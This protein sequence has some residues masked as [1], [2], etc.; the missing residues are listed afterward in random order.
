MA[1]AR[2][3]SNPTPR[4][5]WAV[6]P[7]TA[8]MSPVGTYESS[9]AGLDEASQESEVSESWDVE[10]LEDAIMRMPGY[11]VKR[12][13]T[14][15]SQR[16]HCGPLEPD[17]YEVA[18]A[19]SNIADV[20]DDRLGP[21]IVE[22]NEDDR[23]W[24]SLLDAG[25][26]DLCEEIVKESDFES[27]HPDWIAAVLSMV[28][29]T[30]VRCHKRSVDYESP[31]AQQVLRILSR[32]C[33]IG[34]THRELFVDDNIIL[35]TYAPGAASL[36]RFHMQHILSEATYFYSESR[37]LPDGSTVA[38]RVRSAE[39]GRELARLCMHLWY[40]RASDDDQVLAEMLLPFAL[41]AVNLFSPGDFFSLF[42]NEAIMPMGPLQFLTS[43]CTSLRC[44]G[45]GNVEWPRV[46]LDRLLPNIASRPLWPHYSAS[47]FFAAL[48]D[49]L[50]SNNHLGST[51]VRWRQLDIALELL[52]AVTDV[53]PLNDAAGPLIRH[54]DIVELIAHSILV[55]VQVTEASDGVC[56]RAIDHYTKIAAVLGLRSGK[57]ALK[58]AF[59]QAT[60]RVWY[61]TLKTLRD[62]R[63]SDIRGKHKCKQLILAWQV[64]GKTLD[65]VEA[66]E[67]A[68]YDRE[69]KAAAH[70]CGWSG[71]KYHEKEPPHPVRT[72]AGCGEVRYCSRPCQQKDWREGGH[73][74]KCKRLKAEP[75]QSRRD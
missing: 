44:G 30:V 25:I 70:L 13:R 12:L 15:Y 40:C 16:V 65:L 54:F 37:L 31:R 20:I 32:L 19:F 56:H 66:D 4:P 62:H 53:A 41:N 8:D 42:E 34:N 6:S 43:V 38:M 46:L 22:D 28:S 60:Q 1:L 75:H 51:L 17:L 14:L 36:M 18:L 7:I 52:I 63:S 57:N 72:C 50:D 67:K 33:H 2:I 29:A 9:S 71:C 3:D 55:C 5:S 21:G 45:F 39:E 10:A 61:R 49:M 69:M 11:M 35:E 68:A 59:Q 26:S 47:G 27:E 24:D 74:Q 23:L 73:K 64:F 48:R 58:E